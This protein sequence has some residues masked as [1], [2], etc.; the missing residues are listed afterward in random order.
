MFGINRLHTRA[1]L[2][3]GQF[4]QAADGAGTESFAVWLKAAQLQ[5]P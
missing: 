3:T 4:G 2:G 5:Q 1:I